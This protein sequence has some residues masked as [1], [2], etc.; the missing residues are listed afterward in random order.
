[1]LRETSMN[2]LCKSYLLTT[3]GMFISAWGSFKSSLGALLVALSS[4]WLLCRMRL[5]EFWKLWLLLSSG[6]TAFNQ[7]LPAYN[8]VTLFKFFE[9][10]KHLLYF[11]L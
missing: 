11:F 3:L 2:C 9:F 1:M 5:K 4:V 7:V 6:M 8:S 10:E